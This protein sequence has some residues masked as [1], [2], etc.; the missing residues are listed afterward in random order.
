LIHD[1][2]LR[3]DAGCAGEYALSALLAITF[4]YTLAFSHTNHTPFS[5]SIE[6][7][8]KHWWKARLD[9]SGWLNQH[10]QYVEE[11]VAAAES[12]VSA[13]FEYLCLA[14]VFLLNTAR[15]QLGC[16]L[17]DS[18]FLAFGNTAVFTK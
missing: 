8:S 7:H 13:L 2:E 10:Q 17:S 14:L 9:V 1:S 16:G 11:A 18:C 6:Q 12:S 5:A 4:M 15:I 3:P